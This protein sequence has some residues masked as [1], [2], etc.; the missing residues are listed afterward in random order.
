LKWSA[1]CRQVNINAAKLLARCLDSSL[2]VGDLANIGANQ[3]DIAVE[4]FT[5]CAQPIVI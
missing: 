2:D 1:E 3:Q 4:F 5:G